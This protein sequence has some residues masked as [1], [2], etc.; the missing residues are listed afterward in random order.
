MLDWDPTGKTGPKKPLPDTVTVHKPKEVRE[1]PCGRKRLC[2]CRVVALLPAR[3][4]CDMSAAGSAVRRRRDAKR[5]A[6]KC[7]GCVCGGG[8]RAEQYCFSLLHASFVPETAGP[9][10]AIPRL[11]RLSSPRVRAYPS[12]RRTSWT[13]RSSARPPT[14]KRR[15]A[16]GDRAGGA[17]S[18]GAPAAAAAA[19]HRGENT[20]SEEVVSEGAAV[21]SLV[22]GVASLL[23]ASLLTLTHFPRSVSSG[24]VAVQAFCLFIPARAAGW[25]SRWARARSWR[26]CSLWCRLLGGAA[27]GRVR[28]GSL[29]CDFVVRLREKKLARLLR[30][31]R[32]SC[33]RLGHVVNSQCSHELAP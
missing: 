3:V 16:W 26:A 22:A 8:A 17:R 31:R 14:I 21:A 33:W 12:P 4:L 11:T 1:E 10:Q 18:L 7:G 5:G 15:L 2:C 30:L 25:R 20:V 23:T 29:P 32:C 6:G 9:T 28:G 19:E 24:A 27:S 13:S